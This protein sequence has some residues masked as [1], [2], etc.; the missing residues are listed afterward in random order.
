MG[1]DDLRDVL[2]QASEPQ[3]QVAQRL[4]VKPWATAEAL[5]LSDDALG[6]I[7]QLVGSTSVLGST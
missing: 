3:D 2:Q 1:L 5:Q 6:A 4:T 7:E